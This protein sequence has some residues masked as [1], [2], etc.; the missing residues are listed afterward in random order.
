[1]HKAL[2]NVTFVVI[3]SVQQDE[4]TRMCSSVTQVI[5]MQL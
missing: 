2:L 5:K 1:M 4:C 3:F